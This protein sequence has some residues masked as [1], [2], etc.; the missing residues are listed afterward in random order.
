MTQPA[1]VRTPTPRTAPLRRSG[2]QATTGDC[3]SDTHFLAAMQEMEALGLRVTA[4]PHP[5]SRPFDVL[6]GRGHLRWFVVPARPRAVRIA[7]LALIQP[8]RPSARIL[9][10]AMTVAA[11]LGLPHLWRNG[12]VHVSG[13]HR[14]A[15]GFDAA[16]SQAAFLTG[17]AGPHRKLTVQWMDAHGGIRGYAKVSRT[18][19]VQALL[20]NEGSVLDQ[21]H[22]IRLHSAV[23]PR[24]WLREFR[25]DGASILAMDTVRTPQQPC[26]TRLHPSHLVFLEEL[27]ARTASQSMPDGEGLLRDLRAQVAQLPVPLPEA[28]RQRFDLALR[29]LAFAPDLIAPHGLPG[30][31]LRVRLGIRRLRVPGGLRPDPF[32]ARAA[33]RAPEESR[34]RLPCGRIDPHPELQAP[35]G[36]GTCEVD[37]LP[38][39]PGPDVGR[40]AFEPG[41]SS[42]DLGRRT[43]RVIDAGRAGHAWAGFAMRYRHAPVCARH[44][45]CAGGAILMHWKPLPNKEH[46]ACRPMARA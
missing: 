4:A 39:R 15:R 17:T 30:Q 31:A 42:L 2:G 14:A 11:G 27:A 12:R 13:T 36:R 18:P 46:G 1:T 26:C 8:L 37:G 29:G 23:V 24:V 44:R 41:R 22:G 28:W 34:R 16:A 32:P 10:Q 5:G 33:L 35:A 19:A 43:S 3:F 40:T 20:A 9:K 21:L 6:A 25:E 7:S 45:V 38:L